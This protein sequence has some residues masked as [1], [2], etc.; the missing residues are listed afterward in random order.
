M[1][2]IQTAVALL[3]LATRAVWAWDHVSSS[4]LTRVIEVGEPVLVACKFLN[5]IVRLMFWARN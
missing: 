3:L 5:S 4:E 1:V 2:W